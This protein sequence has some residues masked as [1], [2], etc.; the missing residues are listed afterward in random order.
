MLR[1]G[2]PKGTIDKTLVGFAFFEKEQDFKANAPFQT[3]FVSEREKRRRKDR[4]F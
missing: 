2:V 3:E 1:T 4:R